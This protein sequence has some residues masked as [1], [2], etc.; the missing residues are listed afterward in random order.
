MEWDEEA[1]K[2]K[3]AA[4]SLC[5]IGKILHNSATF[6]EEVTVMMSSGGA[7]IIPRNRRIGIPPSNLLI[8]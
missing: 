7:P 2:K 3:K 6:I 5:K 8:Q 1:Y 4:A